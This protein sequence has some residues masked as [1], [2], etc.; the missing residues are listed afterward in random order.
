MSITLAQ[1]KQLAVLLRKAGDILDSPVATIPPINPNPVPINLVPTGIKEPSLKLVWHDEFDGTWPD[2]KNWRQGERGKATGNHA[3][4]G[5]PGNTEKQ[6][7]QV[8]SVTEHDSFLDLKA[9]KRTVQVVKVGESDNLKNT[10]AKKAGTDNDPD[11]YYWPYYEGTFKYQSGW[12]STGPDDN[13]WYSN[14]QKTPSLHE[15][16]YGVFE[17]RVKLPKGKGFWPAIWMLRSDKGGKDEI[18]VFEM[19]DPAARKLAFHYHCD[20][21][22]DFTN[23]PGPGKDMGVDLS[24]DFHTVAVDW[25]ADYIRW[26]F[27]GKQV[28]TTEGKLDK[29]K[30]CKSPMYIIFNLAIGGDWPG[31]P[32]NTSIFPQSMLIDYARVWNRTA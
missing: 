32:D 15:F 18:D 4:P 23:D 5:Y 19:V 1:Q 2:L 29:A 9:S 22:P 14:W 24:A 27:D 8:E 17:F 3:A 10:F 30:I 25:T 28:S 7:Y 20:A 11:L 16:L 21:V 13:G 12:A 6:F 31:D 26:Y